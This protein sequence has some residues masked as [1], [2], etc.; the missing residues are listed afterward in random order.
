MLFTKLKSDDLDWDKKKKVKV[1]I[2]NGT[3]GVLA[4]KKNSTTMIYFK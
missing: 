2:L 4:N 1:I 3:E